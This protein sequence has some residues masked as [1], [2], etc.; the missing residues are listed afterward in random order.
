MLTTYSRRRTVM[1]EE[2][3]G[4]ERAKGDWSKH[5]NKRYVGKL[6]RQYVSM[7]EGYEVEYFIDHYLDSRGKAVSNKN[8]DIVTAALESYSGKAPYPRGA[9][10]AFLDSKWGLSAVR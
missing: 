5:D 8:R 7:S 2:E 6:D 9:L 4:L 10:T 1:T 3:K